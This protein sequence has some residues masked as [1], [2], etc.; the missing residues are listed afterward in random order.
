[1]IELAVA[2][3]PLALDEAVIAAWVGEG[4]RAAAGYF[5]RFPAARLRLLIVPVPGGEIHG[6]TWGYLGAAMRLRLGAAVSEADLAE[7]WVLHHELAHVAFPQMP[8]AQLWLEEGTATYA[9]TIARAQ[10]GLMSAEAV[11]REFA[12]GMPKGLPQEGDRGLDLTPTW[13]RTYWGGAL[14]CLL[15]DIEIRKRTDNRRGLQDALAAIV[16]AGGNNEVDWPLARVWEVGDGAT[17][18]P[19]LAELYEAMRATPVAVDIAALWRALGVVVGDGGAVTFDDTAPLA[20]IRRAITAPPA[21][22]G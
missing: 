10:A 2:P 15:A 1:V 22:G 20:A 13:G 12:W 4:A 6:A 14:F 21:A 7:D 17:G 16:A 11:W 9:S 18:V 8:E 3:G 5:G 19:V